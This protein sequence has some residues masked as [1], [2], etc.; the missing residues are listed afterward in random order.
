MFATVV[1]K[2]KT[3]VDF[4]AVVFGNES[5]AGVTAKT[6]VSVIVGAAD[7]LAAASLKS[8]VETVATSTGLAVGVD[9]ASSDCFFDAESC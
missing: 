9:C 5:V 4:A 7:H 3:I 1:I 6:V 8:V 2:V